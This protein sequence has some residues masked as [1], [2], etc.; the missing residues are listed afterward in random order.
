MTN[1][2]FKKTL[3][4]TANKLRGSVSAAE[5]KHPVLGLVFLKYVSDMFDA[6]AKVI[7][8]R[9]AEP[10][11]EY[12]IDDPA[13]RAESADV[14]TG[15]KT[16]YD[17][18]NV[19]WVPQS[20]R[21]D[22]LLAQA[23]A[24]DLAQK[25]DRAMGE[26]EA[27]NPTLK[28]VLYREFSRLPLQPGKLGELMGLVARLNFDPAQHGSRDV[29]GEVYEYF[30]GQFAMNEGAKAGEFDTPKSV[31]NHW[32]RRS[33]EVSAPTRRILWWGGCSQQG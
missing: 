25:L 9:I 17:Q 10:T 4:D 11:S 20:A 13:V 28:G 26:I 24:P 27:E 3:W 19:F 31:V 21:F 33:G 8:D 12:Y 15:D 30:L 16:F 14:F 5:Y 32:P 1:E 6:Q 7:R 18:D 23:T 22:T 29:F 2:E